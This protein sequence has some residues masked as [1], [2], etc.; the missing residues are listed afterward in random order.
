LAAIRAKNSDSWEA[1]FGYWLKSKGGYDV[2]EKFS[3]AA[4]P[5]A[6]GA[7][8]F[9]PIISLTNSGKTLITGSDI[10]GNEADGI[11]YVLSVTDIVTGGLSSKF[12]KLSKTVENVSARVGFGTSTVSVI[13][14]GLTESNKKK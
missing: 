9:N 1:K 11:D 5:I 8:L 7:V 12:F 14:T 13:K 10:Y 6:Q 2:D 4:R 3:E